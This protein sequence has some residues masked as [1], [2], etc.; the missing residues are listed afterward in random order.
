MCISLCIFLNT[1]S[2]NLRFCPANT[3]LF[4]L[5]EFP[6]LVHLS[7]NSCSVCSASQIFP[8]SGQEDDFI[9]WLIFS[10]RDHGLAM[11]YDLIHKNLVFPCKTS[12]VAQWAKNPSAMQE[13]QETWVKFL[14]WENSLEDAMATL[15]SILAWRIQW[16]EE[17]DG[18]QSM[19]SQKVR[20]D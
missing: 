10:L 18:L 9:S 15:S 5:H 16:T 1:T 3:G 12:Q 19:G 8:P 13:M 7:E 20:H 17:P 6:S 2:S 4:G 11:I 14:V